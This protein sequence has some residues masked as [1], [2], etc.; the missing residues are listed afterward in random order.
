MES[1]RG[2]HILVYVAS[3]FDA[4]LA[5]LK[6][7]AQESF[8]VYGYDRSE[9]DSV[10]TYKP[11]SRHGFPEDLATAKAVIA[12]AGFTLISEAMSLRKPYL[13]LPMKGQFEQQLN[14]YLLEKMGYGKNVREIDDDVI[15]EF[16]Y[17]I[18][19][20]D[21]RFQDYQSTDNQAIQEKLDELLENDAIL[22]K[23][24]QANRT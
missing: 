5:Q 1:R 6:Q 13:A 3:G 15:G 12:T 8:L 4:L 2:D 24:F 22:A 23:D 9:Q 20:Y 19:R 11:F 21:Q 18:P 16:L 14:G 7:H 10:L 17:D